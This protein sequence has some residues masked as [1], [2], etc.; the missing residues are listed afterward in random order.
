MSVTDGVAKT[1]EVLLSSSNKFHTQTRVFPVLVNP[2]TTQNS[3]LKWIEIVIVWVYYTISFAV[4]F[5][6][7]FGA[8]LFLFFNLYFGLR[9]T[10]E[11]AVPKLSYDPYCELDTKSGGYIFLKGCGKLRQSAGNQRKSE[12]IDYL[13]NLSSKFAAHSG[14][15]EGVQFKEEDDNTYFLGKLLF[16]FIFLF[17]SLTSKKTYFPNVLCNTYIQ[18]MEHFVDKSTPF[19]FNEA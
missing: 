4:S 15:I 10:G 17:I 1:G 8:L 18:I 7:Q 19:K 2:C 13:V 3:C 14:C 11:G 6:K 9:V 12:K 5:V 16:E